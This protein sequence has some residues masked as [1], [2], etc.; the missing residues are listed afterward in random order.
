MSRGEPLDPDGSVVIVGAGLGGL[1]SA[2][3]LRAHGYRGSLTLVGEERRPP[4]DRPPLTKQL[5]AGAWDEDRVALTTTEALVE[6]GIDHMAGVRAVSLEAEA[7]EVR[8]ADGRS[9]RG[10]AVVLATGATPR[11]LAGTEGMAGVHVIRTMEQSL[12]LRDELAALGPG[13]RVVVVGAGFIGGEVASTAAAGGCAVTVV[14]VLEVPLSPVVGEE[15]GRW[16]TEL[17]RREGIEVRTGATIER[18]EPRRTGGRAAVVLADGTRL[19]AD[20]VV[21]GIGVRPETAW[22]EGSGVVLQDGVVTD[23][24]LFAADGVVAVGDLARFTWHHA[25]GTEQVR[26]EHWEVTA[27]LA[28]HAAT[29]LLAGRATAEQVSL[30]PYFWSDQ[31]GRKLQML[32]RPRGTDDVTRVAGSLDEARFTFLTHRDGRVTGVVGLASPRT[33]MRSR[34][35]VEHGT[36]IA[37]AV[38]TLG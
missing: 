34:P 18:V 24:A 36:P 13:A 32:G 2:E 30:V 1:R 4:Y 29:A 26:I 37:E 12:A 16:I 3:A 19:D 6:R 28:A 10:D 33:V 27:Q 17:H 11:R 7:M 35:F 25:L 21:V 23:A 38:A 31:H 15:V 9:L 20:V 22:L 5:L 14:D 8:L